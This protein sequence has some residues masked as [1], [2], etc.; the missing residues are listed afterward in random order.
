VLVRLTVG[1]GATQ[2]DRSDIES[3]RS[4]RVAGTAGSYSGT[5]RPNRIVGTAGRDG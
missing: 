4:D 2:G 5:V 3:I 1:W